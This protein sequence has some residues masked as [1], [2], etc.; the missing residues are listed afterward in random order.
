MTTNLY[1][2]DILVDQEGKFHLGEINGQNSGIAG[3][4]KLYGDNRVAA[5]IVSTLE[6]QAGKITFNNGEYHLLEFTRKHPLKSFVQVFFEKFAS[7]FPTL[8]QKFRVYHRERLLKKYHLREKGYIDW[9]QEPIPKQSASEYEL[10]AYHGQPSTVLNF[11]NHSIPDPSVNSFEGELITDNKLLQYVLLKNQKNSA[12]AKYLIPTIAVGMG[13]ESHT[14]I[15]EL[16][17][18]NDTFVIKPILGC[19]GRGVRS[20]SA[21]ELAARKGLSGTFHRISLLDWVMPLRHNPATIAESIA[22]HN[23]TF[24]I[25]LAIVQPFINT[26]HNGEYRSIRAIVCCDKF[27][28][29]YERRSKSIVVNLSQGARVREA[30]YHGLA[31]LCETIVK[32]YE[33]QIAHN[34][35]NEYIKSH[36]YYHW[37]KNRSNSPDESQ[38]AAFLFSFVDHI[39]WRE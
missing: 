5:K 3:F 10:E 35:S 15:D 7:Y 16:L 20:L 31:D 8:V 12:I 24:E 17:Q 4:R 22:C 33:S 36:L 34:R 1:G 2:L 18:E 14:E 28:D 21:K 38:I 39:H 19:C 26:L 11:H 30:N 6:E 25:G 37:L 9:L 13:A 32:T 27:I 23:Y 29:A